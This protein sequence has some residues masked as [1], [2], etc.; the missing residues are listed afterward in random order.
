M[1]ETIMNGTTFC[2][3]AA[4]TAGALALSVTGSALAQWAPTERV[5]M[6]THSAP[7]TGNELMLREIADIMN[8]N[9][10]VPRQVAVESVT[11]SQ[12]EKAR[13]YVTFQNKGNPHMLAAYTPQSL[14][15]PLLINSD[16]GWRS[17]TPIALMAVDPML[18]VVN[19][20]SS[21]R[22]PRDLLD[23][24][25]QK[26]KQILQGGG[27]YG[28]SASMAGKIFE[29]FGGVQ[30]SYTPFRG[31]GEAI[32]QLLGKHVHFMME[33]PA[34]M[35]QHVKAGK[36][37]AL[38]A[39][40]RLELLPDVPRF[41]DVGINARFPKQFRG[42]MAPQ[43]ISAEAAQYWVQALAKVRET[44]QWKEYVSRNALVDSWTTGP[45]LVAFFEEEE[46]TYMRLNKE[47]SL[48]K[49]GN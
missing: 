27:S 25:R 30:F 5:V 26:P 22:T 24:A 48:L 44:K 7:G 38:A 45:A 21:W 49:P 39:T 12:G 18:L 46:K 11:G 13:R 6:V 16:T 35:A 34:E 43:G 8:K 17:F 2:R 29:D 3:T 14:N 15:L 19:A 32:P 33:N 20:E 31:A 23:A 9:K 47:M 36:L 1:E 42:V 37:R 10:I 4:I 40:E 28:S 41:Q